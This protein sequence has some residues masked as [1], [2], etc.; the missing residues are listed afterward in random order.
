MHQWVQMAG[1][2]PFFD[3]TQEF[4]Q[5]RLYNVY[6][7]FNQVG[8]LA[9]LVRASRPGIRAELARLDSFKLGQLASSA[10][11]GSFDKRVQN[12]NSA[13]LAKLASLLV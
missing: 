13:R 6:S 7:H 5:K 11:L 8:L 2:F 4:Y 12:W 3:N 1:F 10:R 9:Q